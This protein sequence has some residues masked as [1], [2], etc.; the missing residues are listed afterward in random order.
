MCPLLVLYTYFNSEDQAATPIPKAPRIRQPRSKAVESVSA[1]ITTP[2]VVVAFPIGPVCAITTVSTSSAAESHEAVSDM[3][4]EAETEPSMLAHSDSQFLIQ[5]RC[6]NR[7]NFDAL[8]EIFKRLSP[9]LPNK[10]PIRRFSPI[11][12]FP[13]NYHRFPDYRWRMPFGPPG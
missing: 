10:G 4:P 3:Q 2:L 6:S 11:P 13:R 7:Q 12:L 1:P 5:I 8:L 9:T